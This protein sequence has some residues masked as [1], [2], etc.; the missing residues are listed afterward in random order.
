[1]QGMNRGH[2]YE[3]STISGNLQTMNQDGNDTEGHDWGW[4]VRSFPQQSYRRKFSRTI[5]QVKVF[6]DNPAGERGGEADDEFPPAD[7]RGVPQP[8][9]TVKVHFDKYISLL[10]FCTL[11]ALQGALY[12]YYV[13]GFSSHIFE[14]KSIS[15]CP[16]LAPKE[17]L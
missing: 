14:A 2:I 10:H 6:Q 8:S 15:F 17:L 13:F 4:R 16:L 12:W 5:L 11:S 7:M 3:G 1:M 9:L